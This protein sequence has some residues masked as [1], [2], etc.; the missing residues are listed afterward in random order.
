M[1]IKQLTDRNPE[2]QWKFLNPATNKEEFINMADMEDKH[3][4][5]AMLIVQRRKLTNFMTFVNECKRE[6]Q[7]RQEAK[8]RNM[9]VKDIDEVKFSWF[10]AKFTEFEDVMTAAYN[11]I[12]RKMAAIKREFQKDELI[13][14]E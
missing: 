1:P 12:I 10:G 5:A 11:S 9:A 7:L 13:S 8:N 3:L 6:A 2:A 4:Q 14:Q